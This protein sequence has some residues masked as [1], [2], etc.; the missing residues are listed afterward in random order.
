MDELG[1]Q[2]RVLIVPA[3][4]VNA[5]SFYRRVRMKSIRASRSQVHIV[6]ELER[7]HLF[8][9]EVDQ[10]EL[11]VLDHAGPLETPA[12]GTD[13]EDGLAFVELDHVDFGVGLDGD[14]ASTE[15]AGD[16]LG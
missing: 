4:L 10:E 6:Q 3:S 12:G 2:R 1:R 9:A 14:D 13:E 8:L 5:G 7:F 16:G 11:V 15:L